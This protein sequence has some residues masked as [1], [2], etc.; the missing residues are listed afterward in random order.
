[1]T[2]AMGQTNWK[3]NVEKGEIKVTMQICTFEGTMKSTEGKLDREWNVGKWEQARKPAT[4][5]IPV[6]LFGTN[7]ISL[8]TFYFS[9]HY[10]GFR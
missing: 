2:E 3:K 5:I 4:G 10:F 6:Q 1:M 8:K 7:K 9:S